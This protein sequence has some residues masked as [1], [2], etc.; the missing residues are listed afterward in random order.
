MCSPSRDKGRY[1]GRGLRVNQQGLRISEGW[2]PSAC[3]IALATLS[4]IAIRA[5]SARCA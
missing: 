1:C 4:V 3:S 2:E 5:S